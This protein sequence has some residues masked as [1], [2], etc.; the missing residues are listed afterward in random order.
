VEI[1]YKILCFS[2][3]EEFSMRGFGLR[4]QECRHNTGKNSETLLAS[5]IEWY[6]FEQVQS[7]AR[8]I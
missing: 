7:L 8:K 5:L 4:H 6:P 1:I 2:M 3:F